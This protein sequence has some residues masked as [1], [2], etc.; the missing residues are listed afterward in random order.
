MTMTATMT[1][2]KT[3]PTPCMSSRRVSAV[4]ACILRRQ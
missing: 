1:A 2:T 4:F 3:V